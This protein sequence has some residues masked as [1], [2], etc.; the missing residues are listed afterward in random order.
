MLGIKKTIPYKNLD[1]FNLKGVR[2]HITEA[3]T[4][5]IPT[6]NGQ[7]IRISN[8]YVPPHNSEANKGGESPSTEENARR[9]GSS[10]GRGKGRGT[11]RGVSRGG[12]SNRRITNTGTAGRNSGTASG[13]AGRGRLSTG[14]RG[15]RTRDTARNEGT[16][17]NRRNNN[18]E[19]RSRQEKDQYFNR[20]KWAKNEYERGCW[21]AQ[22]LKAS[23]FHCALAT[24]QPRW[25]HHR[26]TI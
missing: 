11:S 9:G 6:C 1:K 21:P 19:E 2:D 15:T 7:K 16:Q 12:S 10:S 14:G 13:R 18:T 3:Q 22:A 5:E 23:H 26:L 24:A 8:V 4:I 20:N 25:F 17:I